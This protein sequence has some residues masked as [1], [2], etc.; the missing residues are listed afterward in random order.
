MWSMFEPVMLLLSQAAC[1]TALHKH[2]SAP[3]ERH[4][5]GVQQ[6]VQT[7]FYNVQLHIAFLQLLQQLGDL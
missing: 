1:F 2:N 7:L 4:L 6:V 5:L 3:G